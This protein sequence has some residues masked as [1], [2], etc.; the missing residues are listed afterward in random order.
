[1]H[2]LELQENIKMYKA[3]VYKEWLKIRWA[4]AAMFILSILIVTYIWLM[5]SKQMEFN[6]AKALWGVIIFRKYKFFNDLQYIPLLIGAVIGAAQY[7]PES[8]QSRL[9]LTLHLPVKE[10]KILMQM[11]LTGFLLIAA[12]YAVITIYLTAIT[13]S[14]FPREIVYDMLTTIF[15]WMLGGSAAYFTCGAVFVEPVWSRRIVL[16]IFSI[17][18]LSLLYIEGDHSFSSILLFTILTF[19]FPFWSLLT[20]YHF[21]RGIQ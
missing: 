10:N 20:G 13:S 19:L 17:A 6:D 2:L 8:S 4:Y 3:I 11:L 18:F 15:P 12:L 16:L 21:K 1:M 7:A 5:L 9:K 14:Y